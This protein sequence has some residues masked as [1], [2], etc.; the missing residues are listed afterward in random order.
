MPPPEGAPARPPS[1]C[2]SGRCAQKQA[3][4]LPTPCCSPSNELRAPQPSRCPCRAPPAPA[5]GLAP[6]A[7]RGPQKA[8]GRRQAP[9]SPRGHP[10]TS[11]RMRSTSI[12]SGW[13]CPFF[14]GL[15]LK[16][17][18]AENKGPSALPTPP[19]HT[20]PPSRRGGRRR[21]YLHLGL[22]DGLLPYL[23]VVGPDLQGDRAE[24]AAGPAPAPA[25]PHSP[26]SG[27]TRS[28][29]GRARP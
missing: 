25:A 18:G 11:P 24:A 29:H 26:S 22:L 14:F 13:M 7:A 1:P 9:S 3:P 20:P 19:T 8:P 17:C 5:R 6:V 15:F 23:L 21:R 2:S 27:T 4:T 10:L 28:R 12:R 16:P